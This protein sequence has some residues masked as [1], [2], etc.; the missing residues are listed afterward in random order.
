MVR[1]WGY[2]SISTQLGCLF[3]SHTLCML[4]ITGHTAFS[5]VYEYGAR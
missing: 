1:V 2:A 5:M 3:I 4:M